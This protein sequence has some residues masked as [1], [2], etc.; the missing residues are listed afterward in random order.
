MQFLL[1]FQL[2]RTFSAASCPCPCPLII[3]CD[4]EGEWQERGAAA[5][6]VTLGVFELQNSCNF[7][8]VSRRLKIADTVCDYHNA[9]CAVC[10]AHVACCLLLLLLLL[11][12]ACVALA[13]VDLND[14]YFDKLRNML[15]PHF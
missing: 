7:A 5:A 11:P 13:V 1:G 9:A 2:C 15:L 8:V 14:D 12:V 4:I 3:N 10:V 6:A